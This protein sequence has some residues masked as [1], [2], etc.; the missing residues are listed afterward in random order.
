MKPDKAATRLTADQDPALV[1]RAQSLLATMDGRT[2]QPRL[3]VLAC[4]LGH[5]RPLSHADVQR[6][7]PKL[8][9]VSAYRSLDWLADHKLLER[10]VGDDGL[11]R[12]AQRDPNHDHGLHPHFQCTGCGETRCL[13]AVAVAP[14]ELPSGYEVTQV[15]MNMVGTCP[16]C[17]SA[18]D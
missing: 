12:Y 9:R 15:S 6:E 17:S 8:D 7:L 5:D 16:A 13:H 1:Q 11:R 4:L 18:L 3:A 14:P 10:I 2:T